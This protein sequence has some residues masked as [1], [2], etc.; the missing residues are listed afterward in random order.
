MANLPKR[1]DCEASRVREL[2][3]FPSVR[4]VHSFR[5]PKRAPVDQREP[6]LGVAS[7]VRSSIC[8]PI[9][10]RSMLRP[11]CPPVQF[12]TPKPTAVLHACL[13]AG[14]LDEDPAHCLRCRREEMAAALPALII[15]GANKTQ[16]RFVNEP[17]LLGRLY[18]LLPGHFL[19]RQLP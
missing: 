3:L 2:S 19:R 17:S 14:I 15:R 10:P 11:P 12:D 4:L 9:P 6:A 18:R 5:V 8:S 1:N 16:V 7:Q 13:Q